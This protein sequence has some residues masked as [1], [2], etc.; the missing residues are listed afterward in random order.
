MKIVLLVRPLAA[1]DYHRV[2]MPFRYLDLLNKEHLT[3]IEEGQE[4]RAS[5]FRHADLVIFNRHPTVDL[6]HLLILRDKYGFKMWVDIDDYWELYEGH[7]LYDNWKRGR[8]KEKMIKSMAKADI[9]TTTNKRLLRS[10]LP[11]NEKVKII[12]NAVPVGYEQFLS[13]KTESTRIRFMYAGGPSH[14]RDLETLLPFFQDISD[15]DDYYERTEFILAGFNDKV[16]EKALHQMNA[17]MG[18]APRYNT[19]NGLP[20][21][22]YMSHYNQTDIS[23]A[24]LKKNDFNEMK[25]NLKIIEAGCM[26]TAI[27]CPRIYPYLEDKEMVG[28]GIYFYET[29][30]GFFDVCNWLIRNPEDIVPGADELYNYVME[31]YNLLEVNKLRREIINSFKK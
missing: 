17:I 15:S 1:C 10:I 26:R 11:I 7:Y 6:E 18:L 30:A 19:L 9:I 8:I 27:I 5:E 13:Q 12:P 4:I 25:S 2:I 22:K 20:L 28:K 31:K 24:P 29:A 21:N 23:I 16:K 3:I 14:V